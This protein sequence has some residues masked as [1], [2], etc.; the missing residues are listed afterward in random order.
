M[1]TM[2]RAKLAVLKIPNV[3]GFLGSSHCWRFVWK[4]AEPH[5]IRLQCACRN[6]PIVGDVQY[7]ASESF[8][9]PEPNERKRRI[10]LHARYLKF[11]HPISGEIVSQ[12]APLSGPWLDYKIPDSL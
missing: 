6:L 12:T 1:P 10:G 4:P 11:E 8:G 7:N 5:Q 9:P 2:M 3:N